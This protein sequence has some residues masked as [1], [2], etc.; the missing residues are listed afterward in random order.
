MVAEAGV[1]TRWSSA[2]RFTCRDAVAV[3]VPSVP[4]TVWGPAT[5]AVQVAPVQDPSGVMVG[6]VG[7][8][9][10]RGAGP[11]GVLEG[12]NPG[13]GV[14]GAPPRRDRRGARGDGDVV[15]RPR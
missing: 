7:E 8:G 14:A 13:G 9:G 5:E 15:Q 12:T 1:R 2:P 4:V 6:A 10:G 3:L 11:R